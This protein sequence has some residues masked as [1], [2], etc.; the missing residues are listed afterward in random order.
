MVHTIP[1][2][3]EVRDA[4]AAM[5]Y[6]HLQRLADFSGVPFHTLR[7]IRDGE[8]ANPGLET[9]RKFAPFIDAARG[10]GV[11]ALVAA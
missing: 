8:T 10:D 4:L 11:A 2:A 7:K 5:K 3:Q 1:S 6:V 9:V